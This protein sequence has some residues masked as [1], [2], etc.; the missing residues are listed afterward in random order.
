MFFM[1]FLIFVLYIRFAYPKVLC[2]K[3]DCLSLEKAMQFVRMCK[4]VSCSSVSVQKSHCGLSEL[5]LPCMHVFP[6]DGKEVP[7]CMSE[8]H[9]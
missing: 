6:K 4:A 9:G 3:V 1:V 5:V 2:P 8:R 7:I